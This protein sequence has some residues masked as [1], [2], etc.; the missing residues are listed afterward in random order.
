MMLVSHFSLTLN[1]LDPSLPTR[2]VFDWNSPVQAHPLNRVNKSDQDIARHVVGVRQSSK[3]F[4]VADQSSS[5]CFRLE[6]KRQMPNAGA[7]RAVS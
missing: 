1:V 5:L 7:K 6:A 2:R 4:P 3:H